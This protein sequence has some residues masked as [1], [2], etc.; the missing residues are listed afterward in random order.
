ME[1]VVS[2]ILQSRKREPG[3]LKKTA[4]ISLAFHAVAIV[5]ILMIPSV[6]PRAAQPPRIM[7][8]ISLGGAPGPKSGGMQTI[9][10]RPIEAAPPS[11]DPQIQKTPLPTIAPTPPK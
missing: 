4:V 2:D 5:I 1:A 6:M 3:G 8:S 10:G 7:M 9:G 11:V